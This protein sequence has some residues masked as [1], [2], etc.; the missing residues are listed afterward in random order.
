MIG[1]MKFLIVVVSLALW[2]V[3]TLKIKKPDKDYI[4]N[5][6]QWSVAI[7]WKGFITGLCVFVVAIVFVS[8]IGMVT[9]GHRG[10]VLSFGGVTG[11][12]LGEGFYV[13]IPLTQSVEVM[14]VRVEA[15]EA[16]AASAS[17][18]L[19]EVS[20]KITLNYWVDPEQVGRVFQTLGHFYEDRIIKPAIQEAVK[21]S[22]AQFDAEKL[23][24]ERPL[25]KG[26]IELMLTERLKV[27]GIRVDAVS[28][29]D[30]S[31]SPDF[32]K[33]IEAK[34]TASQLAL[35]AQRDLERIKTEAQQKIESAKAEAE[36]L[37]LQKEQVTPALLQLRRIENE[38]IALEKW[39]GH[40]PTVVT[41]NSAVPIMDIFGASK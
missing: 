11:R 14:S 10:V 27:H 41:G 17:R 31:F 3:W 15:Y 20:T 30:F 26:K 16:V 18:D 12:I 38:R 23:I 13:I 5:I 2:V 35:K 25:V 32:T 28:L 1:F 21:A 29:T 37:R 19:Q 22:T 36:A 4:S 9:A 40:L 34:V 24:T 7:N 8:S 33:A 39:D 6:R